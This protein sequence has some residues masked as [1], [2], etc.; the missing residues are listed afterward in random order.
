MAKILRYAKYAAI[1]LLLLMI[2]A[3][4]YPQLGIS[5]L[6][7]SLIYFAAGL[8][9]YLGFAHIGKT[10]ENALLKNT[11]H[12]IIVFI[13]LFALLGILQ[14]TPYRLTEEN[15]TKEIVLAMTLLQVVYGLTALGFGLSLFSLEKRFGKTAAATAIL[16]TTTGLLYTTGWMLNAANLTIDTLPK[17]A[18]AL[19]S[20]ILMTAVMNTIFA[21]AAAIIFFHK[22]E[23]KLK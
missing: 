4:S 23:K 9:V 17:V 12:T 1:I 21:Q 10:T 2:P 3:V 19:G 11:A 8:V 6:A 22:T 15:A 14:E 18:A 5:G 20:V 7:G 13:L 16:Y